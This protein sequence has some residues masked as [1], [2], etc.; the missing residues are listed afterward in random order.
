MVAGSGLRAVSPVVSSAGRERALHGGASAAVA[1]SSTQANRL[2]RRGIRAAAG[3]GSGG[4]IEVNCAWVTPH[5][6]NGPVDSRREAGM[7][8]D[9]DLI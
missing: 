2:A 8:I 3:A 1:Q 6:S 7:K 9:E 5:D 4:V